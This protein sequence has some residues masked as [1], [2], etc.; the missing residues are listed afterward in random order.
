MS[1]H[2]VVVWEYEIRTGYWKPYSPA[3]SQHLE[4]AN[5]KQLT[6][7]ILSDADPSLMNYF[8][9]LR[10]LT[11]ESEDSDIVVPVRRKCYPPTSP[12]GKGARWE[13]AGSC[14]GSEHGQDWHPF[15]MDI[16]CLIE[17]AWANGDQM[18]DMS[19]THLG[20]P[21]LINFSNLTQRWLTNGYVRSV[22]RIKQAPYPLVKV[23]LEELAPTTG[24]RG[25]DI[26]KSCHSINNNNQQQ[27]QTAKVIGSSA[28]LNQTDNSKRNSNANK[29][30]TSNKLKNNSDTTPATL[31]RQILNNLN[32]FGHKSANSAPSQT[33]ENRILLDADS[34]STKSGRR[35]SLD[36]VS[37][38]L[39][40]ESRDS[41]ATTS[42]SDL[43]NCSGS[44]DGLVEDLPSIIGMDPASAAI[45]RY[46]RISKPSEWAPRQPCPACRQPLAVQSAPVDVVVALPCSH[47][48]HL[49]C[50]NG[51]LSEQR[52]S[53][54]RCMYAQCAVCGRV[55]GEKHGNQPPG[56]MEWGVVDRCLPGFKG[57]RTIQIVYN[58]QSGIQGPDHPNP[59]REYYAVGF[60]RIAYL[61]DNPK[62]RRI[63]RLLKV[64]WQRKLIFTVSRS[65]TTG[66]EDVVSWN[67][68]HKTEIG[69]SNNSHSYPDSG[70]LTRV[71]RE[72]EALGVVDENATNKSVLNL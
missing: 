55:Y 47:V 62:G 50:L 13:C 43:I 49:C 38:Y 44:D 46:V 72:L 20:F 34:S 53:G 24:R 5:G 57:C 35:P 2:A 56:A 31:A 27:A 3:V 10:T 60:P 4:R 63:L 67:I 16:Q 64:A 58:I 68:P 40:Q 61:P 17:E 29:K 66:C 11:Q 25:S 65:H 23:R 42:T 37:T 51:A 22:R 48:L 59:G 30:K 45:S 41:R 28:A 54:A 33:S 26:R 71:V 21:Y 12:A 7:V 1:G 6:R 52:D 70:Y 18:L 36:T 9:N 39:S 14:T 15:D 8:V 19:Q 69:P 32:I